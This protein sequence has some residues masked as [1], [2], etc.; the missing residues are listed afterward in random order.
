MANRSPFPKDFAK[1]LETEIKGSIEKDEK[2][3]LRNS[4]ITM[5]VM[6]S[7]KS[8]NDVGSPRW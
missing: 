3:I 8:V 2:N 7:L 5:L 6:R 4:L 1:Q